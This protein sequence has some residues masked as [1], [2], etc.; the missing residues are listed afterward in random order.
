M[1]ANGVKETTTTTGTGTVTLAAVTGSVRFSQAFSTGDIASYAIK[2]G[3]NWEWGIGTVGAGNTLARTTIIATLVAGTY[4]ATSASAITLSGSAD[5]LC[6]EHTGN[7]IA[8]VTPRNG[9]RFIPGHLTNQILLNAVATSTGNVCAMP[10]TAPRR[11]FQVNSLG[12]TI[13]TLGAGGTVVLGIYSD[14]NGVPG[15]LLTSC[16]IDSSTTGRKSATVSTALRLVPGQMYWVALLGLTTTCNVLSIPAT[17][18]II[19]AGYQLSSSQYQPFCYYRL[20]SQSSL[21]S[22]LASAI[23]FYGGTPFAIEV[24][25][26]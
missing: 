15:T 12:L 17:E 7:V 3:D 11:K 8:G 24:I 23:Q 22:S 25:E 16:T 19:D 21:P 18:A 6:A 5:V 13:T 20:T 1:L 4:T 26:S 2:D 14:N 10:F 9:T